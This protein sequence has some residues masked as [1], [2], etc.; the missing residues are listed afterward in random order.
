MKKLK[1]LLSII[2]VLLMVFCMTIPVSAAGKINKS[3]IILLTGQ[4]IQLK[5][6]E[7][8]GG[9][10]WISSKK[11]VATVNKTGKV[12]AK[13]KGSAIITAKAGNKKY[14]CKVTVETP[15]LNKKNVTLKVGER[16]TLK[17]TGTKQPVKWK[18]SRK[19]IVTV[20]NG[21]ITAKKTGTVNVTATVLGKKFTC[22]ITVRKTPTSNN[23]RPEIPTAGS[24]VWIPNSGSKYHRYSSC[25]NMRNP[26]NVS[27]NQAIS[28]GH[29]PCKKCY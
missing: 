7:T 23:A 9:T 8:S 12:L 2:A 19:N 11:S 1:K 18:S 24:G 29:T 21:I 14:T 22:K 25:S 26:R 13:K 10:T 28:M 16:I 3:K 20:K 5:V 4:T 15:K 6:S 17:V 27:E